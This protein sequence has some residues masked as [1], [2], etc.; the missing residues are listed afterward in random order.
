M[1]ITA[2][3]IVVV[4]I[5]LQL[6]DKEVSERQ[7]KRYNFSTTIATKGRPVR[8]D[9]TDLSILQERRNCCRIP[10]SIKLDKRTFSGFI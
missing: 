5:L 3:F 4:F 10:F 1:T 9:S 7:S 6:E 8:D 2:R